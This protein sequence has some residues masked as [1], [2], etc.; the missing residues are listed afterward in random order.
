MAGLD[1]S[2]NQL[3]GTI[4]KSMVQL[5]QLKYLYLF[6]NML[7]G[8]LE[9]LGN[10]SSIAFLGL[11]NNMFSGTIPSALWMFPKLE[12]LHLD[13]NQIEGTIPPQISNLIKLTY[14]SIA[15]NSLT[16]VP[17][18]LF[19]LNNLSILDLSNNRITGTTPSSLGP[20]LLQLILRNNYFSG[21]ISPLLYNNKL[22][23]LDYSINALTGTIPNS[24]GNMST[25][26]VLCLDENN[27]DGTMPDTIYL[28]TDISSISVMR[29]HLTGSLPNS[30][31]ASLNYFQ[32]AYNQ[33]TGIIP[34]TLFNNAV[35]IS[36]LLQYNN[37][38]GSIP[39]IN[40]D[41]LAQ[42]NLANNNL[43]GTIPTSFNLPNLKEL[44]LSFNPFTASTIPTLLE[45]S[46]FLS[47]LYLQSNALQ[48]GIP[49][50]FS[51][52][53]SLKNLDL[54]HNNLDNITVIKGLVALEILNLNSNNLT[55]SIP[56]QIFQL[57][58]LKL[59][60]LSNN[61]FSGTIPSQFGLLNFLQKI[62]FSNNIHLCPGCWQF[63]MGSCN[64]SMFSQ[65]LYGQSN[66]ICERCS[67]TCISPVECAQISPSPNPSLQEPIPVP[68]PKMIIPSPT[69]E[70]QPCNQD[71]QNF[72]YC[73]NMIWVL[74]SSKINEEKT[75]RV[76]DT[77]IQINGDINQTDFSLISSIVSIKGDYFGKESN[78]SLINSTLIIQNNLKINK[79]T[80]YL[81]ITSSINVNGDVDLSNSNLFVDLKWNQNDLNDV[82][83][84]HSNS[85]NPFNLPHITVLNV[86][87]DICTSVNYK[88]TTQSI[89]LS[90]NHCS[91]T[92]I[93]LIGPII[94][95]VLGFFCT[96]LIIVLLI[97]KNA[98]DSESFI[99]LA[100]NPEL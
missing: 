94:G 5:S 10:V 76:A 37:I 20:S 89:V 82:E 39:D 91:S 30:F 83:L 42:L 8:P 66:C 63:S 7:N 26:K 9:N 96:I 57:R 72:G 77:Q 11:A 18:E 71:L 74:N 55:G 16:K 29:N 13:N 88:K 84:I 62:D 21:T 1:L 22:T 41:Q 100:V 31:M 59:L 60:D 27:L 23:T 15:Q 28:L 75:L 68:G 80:I 2:I 49:Q 64:F 97:R 44:D 4:P 86:P 53:I 51:Q 85:S 56:T 61:N 19:G 98:Q 47:S 34:T 90:S 79:G 48:G 65:Q 87:K 70:T 40:L 93:S 73:S 58:Y 17:S 24:I 95:G 32:I 6:N 69:P 43:T 81:T 14:L 33:F 50:S 25:L 12:I 99:N 54:S 35:L 45:R 67:N 78:I 46:T 36:L 38:S 3:S 92:P 52:L